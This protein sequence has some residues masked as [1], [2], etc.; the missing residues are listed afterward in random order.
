LLDKEEYYLDRTFGERKWHLTTKVPLRDSHGQIIGLVGIC[1]DITERKQAEAAVREAEARYRTLVEQIP[2]V[3]YMA[4]LDAASTTFYISP[5]IESLLGFSLLEWGADPDLWRKQLHPD[6]RER[7]LA[8][9]AHCQTSGEPLSTEYRLRARG[10]RMIWV[11]DQ[12]AIVTD[13][14]NQTGSLLGVLLDVTERKRAEDQVQ[15][16]N[17]DLHRRARELAALNLASRAMTSSLDLKE[18]LG[19]V[20]SEVR[21]LL[22]AEG[23]SL[24]LREGQELVFAATDS[25]GAQA[26]MGMRMPATAGIAGA[27]LQQKRAI[28]V[29]EAQSDPRFYSRIDRTT[30]L[31][32]HSLLAV[33]LVFKGETQ[34]VLEAIN[35]ASGAFDEHDSELLEAMAGS[36]A[37]AIANARLYQAEREQYRRL[38]ISQAKLIQAEKMEAL[39]RLIAS[40][41]HEINNPLQAV[42]GCLELFREELGGDARHEKLLRYLGIVETETERIAAIVRR[43]RDFYR[44]ARQDMLPTDVYTVLNSVFE[45]AGKQLQNNNITVERE[46][47]DG[48]PTIQANPDHLKQVF[49]NLVLNAV[50]AMAK[51]GGTLCVR[52]AMDQ[53]QGASGQYLPAVRLEF[54]DTGE[55]MPPE[56]LAN[57]F[58]PFFTTRTSGTGLGLAISYEIIQAH[59]G[60]ITATSQ[61]GAGT[62]FTIL[63]PVEQP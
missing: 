54:G 39:G 61:S 55:G 27:V 45:L 12:A 31:T 19:T 59:N 50:D 52:T 36:A 9:V 13:E 18:V 48:L 38:Q 10:G 41:A 34:G 46:W 23:A 11:R 53:M 43:V 22:E 6:D 32:T 7:V 58:E 5:Q 25:P 35:K 33:P 1:Q 16:L 29:D 40:V 42:M 2:A 17:Q 24:L 4:A 14:A 21:S 15:R 37:T 20:I 3:T 51:R 30:G 44:P 63:L 57:L 26:L 62:T 28:R 56:V 49:L 47:A 60:Q 8:E